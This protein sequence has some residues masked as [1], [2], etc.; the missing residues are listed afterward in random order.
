MSVV[1]LTDRFLPA[2]LARLG[3]LATQGFFAETCPSS[4]DDGH[5]I[6]W[7]VDSVRLRLT[8][9]MGI[10]TWPIPP[11]AR[12]SDEQVI[13]YVEA[14]Y[15]FVSKPVDSWHH[16]FCG[17][18]H[19][20]Q[21]DQT[22]GRYR[23]T[24]QVNELFTRFASGYRLQSGMVRHGT[25][26]VLDGRLSEPLPFGT[27]QHL[28]DLVLLAVEKYGSPRTSDR[29]LALRNLADAYERIKSGY[30]PNKKQSVHELVKRMAPDEE[31]REPLDGVLEAATRLSNQH[32]VRHHEVGTPEILND[33]LLVD[34][35]FHTYYSLVRFALL[36][37]STQRQTATVTG[38]P[39]GR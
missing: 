27:D 3:I 35:L 37:A 15:R 4:C 21:F 20:T 23:Y 2:F 7:D 12:L 38:R 25:S 10:Q 32:G 29:W 1:T 36:S 31:L 8:A 16:S 5:P 28:R 22:A 14:F 17:G 6:Y 19:P 18:D 9:E 39:S 11:D 26:P 30:G 33:A 24:V 34:F 13:E